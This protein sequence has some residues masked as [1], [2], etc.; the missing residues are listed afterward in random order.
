MTYFMAQRP[1]MAKERQTKL[2]GTGCWSLD[3]GPGV[4][5][6]CCMEKSLET[7]CSNGNVNRE[8]S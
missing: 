2:Y 1:A 3:S 8:E 7:L 5:I 6:F 4:N